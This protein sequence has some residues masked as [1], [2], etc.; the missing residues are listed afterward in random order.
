V[1]AV[2]RPFAVSTATS[3]IVEACRH[4]Y[5]E[6]FSAETVD[7]DVMQQLLNLI[8]RLTSSMLEARDGKIIVEECAA[9][10]SSMENNKT[11]GSDGLPKEFYSNFSHLFAQGFVEMQN[12]SFEA[13]ILPPSLRYGLI[14]LACKDVDNAQLLTNWRPISLLN[15]DYKILAKVIAKRLSSVLSHCVHP[16]QTC[17]FPGGLSKITSICFGTSPTTPATTLSKRR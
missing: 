10:I 4:F 9:A 12:Q 11:P 15:V 7:A 14:T 13:G 16:D 1:A 8:D 5:A 3:S 2:M 17:A 6:L